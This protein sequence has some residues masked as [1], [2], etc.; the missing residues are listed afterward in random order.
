MAKQTPLYLRTSKLCHSQR[1][2]LWEDYLIAESY[3]FSLSSEYYAIRNSAAIFDFS[4]LYVYHFSGTDAQLAIN[5]I[6]TREIEDCPLHQARYTVWCN[7]KG[8]VIDD[9]VVMR[10][11]DNIWQIT[12]N[13]DNTNWFNFIIRQEGFQVHIE[14]KSSEII[15]LPVQGPLSGHILT[16]ICRDDISKLGYF[17]HMQTEIEGYHVGISRTGYTGDLGYEVWCKT[18]DALHIWDAIMLAG[19]PWGLKPCGFSALDVA[20]ME[21]GLIW[22]GY[23]YL[24]ANVATTEASLPWEL[25]LGWVINKNKHDF[26]GKQ[27]LLNT[28]EAETTKIFTGFMICAN[29]NQL[30]EM[31]L[32][33]LSDPWRVARKVVTAAGKHAGFITSGA[34]SP[35]LKTLIALGQIF[36]DCLHRELYIEVITEAG[37]VQQIQIQ[38]TP[39]PFLSLDRKKASVEINQTA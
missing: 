4:P 28:E 22:C 32:R 37:G 34:A 21:A 1:W 8:E 3:D 35:T 14:N 9:G 12:S 2:Q 16:E 38:Q 20:R 26:I 31:V 13:T 24:S 11:D 33:E 5:K 25:N 6:V 19:K 15:T 27:A 36:K 7:N 30:N 29:S 17:H 39:L 23:D 10:L 18:E